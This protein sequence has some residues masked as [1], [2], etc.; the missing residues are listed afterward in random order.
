MSQ[1]PSDLITN[2]GRKKQNLPSFPN[3]HQGKKQI[4][5]AYYVGCC[6]EQI[7]YIKVFNLPMIYGQVLCPSSLSREGSSGAEMSN[8]PKVL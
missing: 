2:K 6:S 1:R 7:V 4:A 3:V 8:F 5:I